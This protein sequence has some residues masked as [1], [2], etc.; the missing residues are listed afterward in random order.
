MA[1]KDSAGQ[2]F[3][4]HLVLYP[5]GAIARYRKLHI[6]PPERPLFRSGNNVPL[7]KLKGLTFGI[8]LCYDAHF[9]DLSTRMAVQGADLILMPHASPRGTP[10]AKHRSWMRHLPARAYDNGL[11]VIA[12]NQTGPN[13][14]GLEFPGLALGFGPG[15]EPLAEDLGGE[16]RMRVIDL[17]AETL[18]HVRSHRMRYF[19][20]QSP[21]RTLQQL[22]P[23]VK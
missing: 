6:P 3:A 9:P 18:R 17:K 5:D 4:S 8:Q 22:N 7:F 1:E 15:G 20:P 10:A 12:V 14:E 11:F 21:A 19:L 23:T 16:E 13:G 2:L